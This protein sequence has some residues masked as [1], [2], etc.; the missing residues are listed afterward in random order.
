MRLVILNEELTIVADYGEFTPSEAN[1]FFADALSA[2]ELKQ[3]LPE[4][5]LR[6]EAQMRLLT[7]S[8]AQMGLLHQNP[9]ALAQW[10]RPYILAELH[11]HRERTGLMQ[12]AADKLSGY[13]QQAWDWIKSR[14]FD[15]ASRRL[16]QF[17]KRL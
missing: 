1:N 2:L 3:T 14:L 17:F 15:A 10:M 16:S 6:N 5:M 12:R 11:R 8:L 13:R 9:Q 7:D 4:V